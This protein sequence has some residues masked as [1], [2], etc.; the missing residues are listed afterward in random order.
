MRRPAESSFAPSAQACAK[1]VVDTVPAVMDALRAAMR[2]HV[3]DQLSVPQFRCLIFIARHADCSIS[4]VATFLGVT[5]A[6]AS[7]MVDR[8]VKAG[9]VDLAT[10]ARD[11]R[12]AQLRITEA[13]KAQM[14]S[15]RRDAQAEVGSALAGCSEDDL[16]ALQAG[17]AVLQRVFGSIPHTA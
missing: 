11:R 8:L 10:D 3:G 12:R 16:R 4:A 6:T 17:L 5:L 7:A 1:E 14:R 2:G 13:G 9:S 15:I